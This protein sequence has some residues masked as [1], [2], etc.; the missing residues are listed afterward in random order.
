MSIE[1]SIV[2][3]YHNEEEALLTPLL[4]SLNTQIGIDFNNIQIIITNN[5][6]TK[7]IK[8]LQDTFANYANIMPH[9]IY[10]ECPYKS[11]MGPNRNYGMSLATGKYIMF[12]DCDDILYSP[13]SLNIVLSNILTQ[14][15]DV[16]NFYY[17]KQLDPSA[18]EQ[19]KHIFE[20]EG[21]GPQLLHGKIYK[22][23]FLIQKHI[24]FS[25]KMFAWED[26]YFNQLVLLNHPKSIN[27]DIP[28]YIWKFRSSSVSKQY[29]SELLYQQKHWKDSVLKNY[30][31]LEYLQKYNILSNREFN[32]LFVNT[33]IDQY[34]Y[35]S[36]IYTNNNEVEELY[37]YI[38]KIFDPDLIFLTNLSSI[39]YS[40]NE[41]FEQF[42]Y[43]ITNKINLE[44]IDKKYNIGHFDDME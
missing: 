22:R 4:S 10:K 28:I 17:L 35:G 24:N 42:I 19:T 43:R 38:I 12:C 40:P 27:I 6:E 31:I 44:Q 41:S 5:I 30:Y 18:A 36:S 8:N 9:I 23:D 39:I 25:H 7:K 16:Y 33:L 1:L 15:Y 2:I 14:E 32:T 29:G 21:H 11:S 37:G 13:T 20:I 34:K 3:P 26:M